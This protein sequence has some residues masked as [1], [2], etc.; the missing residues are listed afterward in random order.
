MNIVK[1]KEAATEVIA[2]DVEPLTVDTDDRR[3]SRLGWLVV[4]LGFGGFMLWALF[5]PLDKGVPMPGFVAK[6]SNRQAVQHEQGGT[7]ADI[8][9]RN[10]DQVKKGQ[11]LVRM[12][13]VM[14]QAQV[15]ISR[16]QYYTARAAEARLLAERDG[17]K[18]ISFPDELVKLQGDARVAE[19]IEL[20]RQLFA[21][22][23]QALQSELAGLEQSVAGLKLQIRGLE[24]ARASKQEQMK[25]LK[26][27][28]DNTRELAREG[29]V[30]RARLLELER[31]YAQLSGDVSEDT[32]NLGR[33]RQQVLEVNLR[34]MQRRQDYQKEVRSQLSEVQKEAE[35]LAARLTAQDY[36]LAKVDV[37]SPV[38]GTVVGLDVFTRGAVVPPGF[39]LM[40]VVPSDDPLVVEG[41]L[42]V[43]LIDRVHKGLPVELIFSAFNTSTTPHIPGEVMHVAADRS[44]DE[45]TGFPYYTVRARVTPAG[46]R[47]MQAKK[48]VVQ[49]GMPVELFVKT[50]ERTMMSYLFKPIVDRMSTALSEE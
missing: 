9:V 46:L 45:R 42:P 40:D 17:A 30:A 22:R 37:K 19:V 13:S 6:E 24:E 14:A 11:V 43:N 5:A 21:S 20:Q 18:S 38:D 3:I 33:S 7:V 36:E 27:Q 16:A 8:L 31:L 49:P 2:H 1:H 12:N 39:R 32:G 15:D 34:I 29:Y 10:G 23:Q 48:L 41:Q 4:V 47:E 28:L 35:A 26:E 44:V 25:I 50:G